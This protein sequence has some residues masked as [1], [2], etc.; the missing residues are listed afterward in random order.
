MT[1]R[2]TARSRDDEVG[3]VGRLDGESTLAALGLVKQGRI[4]DLDSTRWHHMPVAYGH[5]AFQVLT[6]RSPDG[7]RNQGDIEW[8]EEGN[9]S[10][11]ESAQRAGDGNDAH[12][13]PTSTD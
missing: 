10:P 8:L 4:Y 3:L 2:P 7:L 9:A 13:A 6:Y 1:P 11:G 12:A 5:P